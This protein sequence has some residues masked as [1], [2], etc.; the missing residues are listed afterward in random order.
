MCLQLVTFTVKKHLAV[1]V[2]NFTIKNMVTVFR[3][4]WDI[5][6]ATNICICYSYYLC[7]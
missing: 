4:L 3:V 7:H 2:Q 6:V 5:F 1:V